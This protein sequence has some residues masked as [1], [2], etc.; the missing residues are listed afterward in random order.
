MKKTSSLK[1]GGVVLIGEYT[2][3]IGPYSDDDFLVIFY[4]TDDVIKICGVAISD[5]L[6]LFNKQFGST[7]ELKLCNV[8]NFTSRILFPILLEDKEFL[9]MTDLGKNFGGLLANF[10]N[11]HDKLFLK[12]DIF[13]YLLKNTKNFSLES[14]NDL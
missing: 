13:N 7:I 12:Q 9:E 11:Q 6:T 2:L 3:P 1:L 5:F 10:F 4:D 14:L 8:T